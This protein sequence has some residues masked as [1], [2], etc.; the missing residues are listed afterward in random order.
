MQFRP[1]VNAAASMYLSR[2]ILEKGGWED[3]Y[4]HYSGYTEEDIA[5]AV[6]TMI[7]YLSGPVLHN[8]FY[9]KYA[10]KKFLKGS[11]YLKPRCTDCVTTRVY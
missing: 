10:G 7:E 11:S 3:L 6:E 5:P 9:K 1:S 8:A 2:V 4:V